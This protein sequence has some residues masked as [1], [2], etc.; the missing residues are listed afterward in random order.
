MTPDEARTLAD[1]AGMDLVEVAPNSAPPV[2][3]I[4]DYG[5]YKYEEKKKKAAGKGKAHAASLKEVKLRP[6]TDQH[7]L[8]FKLNNARRFLMDGDKVKVTVMFR[9]REMVHRQRGYK[10]LEKVRE[11]LGEMATM[12]SNPRMEGRFLSMILVPN[13]DAVAKARKAE[14]EAEAKAQE[15]KDGDGEAAGE[16]AAPQKAKT[17]KSPPAEAPEA[18]VRAGEADA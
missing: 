9:G 3:R 6:G 18:E 12:E 1:E 13:K 2:C 16:E 8:G 17:K 5:K 7:D 11:M 10:Q 14:A 4:M 15:Q